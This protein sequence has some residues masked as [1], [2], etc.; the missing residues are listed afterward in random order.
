MK[1]ESMLTSLSPLQSNGIS[2]DG[3]SIK[4][5]LKRWW[6]R[7]NSRCRIQKP[8]N[9][10]LGPDQD[11]E[12]KIGTTNMTT[13]FQKETIESTI[14]EVT[15]I[16]TIA[17]KTIMPISMMTHKG[18]EIEAQTDITVIEIIIQ[19]LNTNIVTVI[20]AKA[21]KGTKKAI[22]IEKRGDID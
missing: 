16:S 2:I 8:I 21:V 17:V 5:Q 3:L 9:P 7:N 19:I 13:K 20:E 10:D 14:L 18:K 12:A 4:K 22:D 15:T 6:T 11:L 1:G